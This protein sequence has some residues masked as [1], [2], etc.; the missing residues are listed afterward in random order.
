M[1]RLGNPAILATIFWLTGLQLF[2]SPVMGE[3]S[4]DDK[5]DESFLRDLRNLIFTTTDAS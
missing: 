5:T 1:V 3:A 2:H 4:T